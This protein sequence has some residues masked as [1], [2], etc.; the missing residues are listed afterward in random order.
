ML[1]LQSHFSPCMDFTDTNL[2]T[3]GTNFTQLK[4]Y[5]DSRFTF[6]Y[7]L[8]TVGLPTVPFMATDWR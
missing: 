5:R 4:V 2:K 1:V 7:C 6:T 3:I 8:G